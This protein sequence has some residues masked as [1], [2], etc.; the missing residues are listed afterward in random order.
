MARHGTLDLKRAQQ[1]VL[2][3]GESDKER[4]PWRVQLV[5]ILVGDGRPDGAE[6]GLGRL[7]S[8]SW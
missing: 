2:G 3:A 4:I 6:S 8:G 5:A 7:R 1:G